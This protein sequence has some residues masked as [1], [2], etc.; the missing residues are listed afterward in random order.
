[1]ATPFRLTEATRIAIALAMVAGC[2]PP[3]SASSTAV[4]PPDAAVEPRAAPDATS[5]VA[6]V[7]DARV[8][9][10]GIEPVLVGL[11][12]GAP[13]MR[14][15]GDAPPRSNAQIESVSVLPATVDPAPVS[16]TLRANLAAIAACHE[17]GLR[18]NPSI[19]GVVRLHYSV[20]P[21]GVVRALP[22]LDQGVDD[23]V[24]SCVRVRVRQMRHPT[25]RAGI[26]VWARLLLRRAR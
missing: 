21:R 16:A 10:L 22:A 20:D 19:E 13:A 4:A 2:D 6:D 12:Y 14:D 25:S 24:N 5:A 11:A 8:N 23:A 1:M 26:E 17:G 7:A 18:Q 15:L 3:S 9:V